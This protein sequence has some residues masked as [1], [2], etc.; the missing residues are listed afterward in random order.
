MLWIE[1]RG[2]WRE[3]GRRYGEQAGER[4]RSCVDCYA[5][6]YAAE[7]DKFA[8]VVGG[9]RAAAR[10]HCPEL[11]DETAGISEP[12]LLGYRFFN[13]LK[14]RLEGGCSCIFLPHASEGP[15]LGRNCDL[16]PGLGQEIQV[17][18]V[19][20]P[21]GGLATISTTYLGMAARMGVNERGLGLG[22]AR[23]MHVAP[24]HPASTP[25][26]PVTL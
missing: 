3:V 15:L 9:I 23:V 7:P 11:L 14:P 18:H 8:A 20:R 4:L 5:S 25:F 2:T 16:E 10:R 19:C 13:E 22:G 12:L 26:R 21:A 17:C 24:G 1:T 6:W